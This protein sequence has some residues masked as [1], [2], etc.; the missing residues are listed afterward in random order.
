VAAAKPPL[1]YTGFLKFIR[2]DGGLDHKTGNCL[3]LLGKTQQLRDFENF[4]A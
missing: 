1:I 4:V 2:K 3:I